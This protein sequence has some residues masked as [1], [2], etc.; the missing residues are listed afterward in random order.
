MRFCHGCNLGF[1]F[2]KKRQTSITWLGGAGGGGLVVSVPDS[3]L[4]S[5]CCSTG[6]GNCVVFLGEML[7][8]HSESL[9]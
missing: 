4:W 3:T 8:S 9:H 1:N 6:Q 7:N 5:D 2:V